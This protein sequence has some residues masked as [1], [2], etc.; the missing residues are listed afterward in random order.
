[1]KNFFKTYWLILFLFISI[2]YSCNNEPKVKATEKPVEK[3]LVDTL[4]PEDLHRAS[5]MPFDSTLI[6][7][8]LEARPLFKE[9][10][11][12]FHTFYRS[13]NF[14]YAWYDT[15]GLIE[16][17]S[18]LISHVLSLDLEGVDSTIP[19]RED[20]LKMINYNQPPNASN[21]SKPNI[22]TELMLTGQYFNYA[23]KVW[24]GAANNATSV[25]WFL[26]VKKISYVGMLEKN[27]EEG[28]I[29]DNPGS[30]VSPQYTGLKKALAQYREI[31]KNASFT[32]IPELKKNTR[33]KL[34]DSSSLISLIKRRLLLLGDIKETDT[35]DIFDTVF[36]AAIN[37][38]KSRHGM[39]PDSV[40][41]ANMITE[42]NVPLR[43]RIE[44]IMVN[45]ER[46]RWIPVDTTD[47]E[48]ILVNIPEYML[49]YYE[50]NKK[51]WDCGVVVGTP[52]TETVIFTSN[53]TY[54][55]FSP[56]WY[57]PPSILRKE[58][59]PGMKRDKSYLAK[60]NME[61][62]GGNVRQKPGKSNSLGLVKFI[63]P[64]S[65]NIYLHDTPS[66]SLFEKDDRDFSHG[67]IRVSKP[68]DLAMRILRGDSSWNEQKI[69]KAMNAGAERTV[70]LKNPIPVYI[71]YFTSFIDSKGRVNFR[72]DVYKRDQKLMDLLTK[73]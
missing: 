56:Y 1:M 34:G 54:I 13:N 69:L 40:L 30:I 22:E 31:E 72:K 15:K 61:W 73:N 57:V 23:K 10:T 50:K 6:N 4:K 11:P 65:N 14:K 5:I 41:S 68:V 66:K 70:V 32:A 27:L 51:T 44:Q 28:D 16:T 29:R 64:N 46:L 21:N 60:H 52:M 7:Q 19:Y 37:N 43:K 26:P 58:V 45:M 53:M 35:T 67:C 2:F 17:S 24:K 49:H 48:F 62:N 9:F 63:F 8:F 20:F 36:V 38:F 71:G 18:N 47:R 33:F 39:K 25:N 3:V 42:L 12:D 59:L 55:V